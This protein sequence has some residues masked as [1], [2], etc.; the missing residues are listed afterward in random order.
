MVIE[1]KPRECF[2]PPSI[3]G[4]QDLNISHVTQKCVR[5]PQMRTSKKSPIVRGWLNA[6]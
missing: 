6:F 4:S 5:L 2:Q 3:A 1:K